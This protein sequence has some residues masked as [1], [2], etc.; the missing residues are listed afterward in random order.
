MISLEGLTLCTGRHREARAILRTF[1]TYV[2]D[3]LLPNHFP[4]GQRVPLYNTV[5]AT[6]WYFHAID[7]YLEATGDTETL[8]A[9]FPTLESII[10][11]YANGTQF[12][13][14]MDP[15]DGLIRASAPGYQLTWMDAKVN[16]WVVTPRRGKPVEIQALWYNALKLMVDWAAGCGRE[17][18]RYAS[19]AGQAFRSFN[20]RFWYEP[21]R[22]LFDVVDGEDGDD[23]S[24]RPN[25]LFALSLRHSVLEETR[26]KAVVDV[27][28]ERLVT[29]YGVR[30]LDPAHPS[31][32]PRYE[33]DLVARDAA[34]HQ[35]LVWAWL[36]GPFIDAWRR[37]YPDAERT[38]PLLQGLVQ[39]LQ[40]AGVGSVSEVFDAE[41]PHKPRACIAQA[42]S[43]AELL[44]ILASL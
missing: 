29:P 17:Q 38:R 5:D 41:P 15:A 16:G 6:L 20:Q 39:H 9:L 21:G 31:Y 8:E 1:S 27:V 43:V 18:E 28:R 12:G 10:F 42:W 19:L 30:T 36:M 7:R 2:K 11:H 4:E 3:G 22:H 23:S 25:Q 35:G 24:L 14:G 26:W 13:I 44:R 32:K 34:Y 40:D 33:G 37:V